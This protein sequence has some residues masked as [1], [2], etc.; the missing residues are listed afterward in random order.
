MGVEAKGGVEVGVEV[1]VAEMDLMS[2]GMDETGLG[3]E[4]GV[5][6]EEEV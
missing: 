2:E 5:V 4:G 3:E 6:G 1:E